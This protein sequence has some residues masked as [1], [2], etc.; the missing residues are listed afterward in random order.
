MR[1]E[2]E[3]F[4][5]ET[6]RLFVRECVLADVN[7]LQKILGDP[8]VMQFSLKGPLDKKGIEAYLYGTLS[9]YEKNGYGLWALICKESHAF[10]G[11]AGLI[12]QT[13]DDSECVELIYRL[14][15]EYWGQGL[16]TEAA[17]AIKEYAFTVL[18]LDRVVSVQC[19]RMKI[20]LDSQTV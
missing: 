18:R 10:I 20:L 8:E 15:K 12:K 2:E 11:L 5:F 17:F 13:L 7:N 9:H 4:L 14:A 3:E 16:A 19:Y 1:K 6:P